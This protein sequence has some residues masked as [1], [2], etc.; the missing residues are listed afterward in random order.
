LTGKY[1]VSPALEGLPLKA[2]PCLPAGRKGHNI[3]E[4]YLTG[5]PRP[6]GRGASLLYWVMRFRKHDFRKKSLSVLNPAVNLVYLTI[7]YKSAL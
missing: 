2:G 3:E 1:P 5:K 7:T 6:L 4:K